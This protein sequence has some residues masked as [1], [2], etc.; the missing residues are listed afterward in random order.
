[1]R[2]ERK[3]FVSRQKSQL[4]R[5]RRQK[6]AII[7]SSINAR[8]QKLKM[9]QRRGAETYNYTLG[10]HKK[11]KRQKSQMDQRIGQTHAIY[12]QFSKCMQKGG[13]QE[14]EEIANGLE[15]R[16]K[17]SNYIQFGKCMQKGGEEGIGIANGSKKRTEIANGSKK[18]IKMQLYT[19]RQMQEEKEDAEIA[20]GLKKRT[21]TCNYTQFGKKK[22]NCELQNTPRILK[23]IRDDFKTFYEEDLLALL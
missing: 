22:N 23:G 9:I 5:R 16:T 14:E 18:D 1:M 3:E 2:R 17:T 13:G 6:H 11:K 10:K 21:E 8:R 15:K 4:V 7:H 19:I 20:N 12:T